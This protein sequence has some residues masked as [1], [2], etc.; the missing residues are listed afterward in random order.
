LSLIRFVSALLRRTTRTPDP[1][2]TPRTPRYFHFAPSRFSYAERRDQIRRIINAERVLERLPQTFEVAVRIE[3]PIAAGATLTEAH[4]TWNDADSA[5]TPLG[6]PR[7]P[8]DVLCPSGLVNVVVEC[9]ERRS[10]GMS[11][12]YG[13]EGYFASLLVSLEDGKVWDARGET[14]T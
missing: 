7:Q 2:A 4:S 10:G 3:A 5:E 12:Y 13:F 11:S 14:A 6:L 9:I 8:P 1:G